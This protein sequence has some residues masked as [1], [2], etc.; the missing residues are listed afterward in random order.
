MGRIL[1]CRDA[2]RLI[3]RELDA[4]LPFWR[5]LLLRVHLFLCGP[6]RGFLRQALLLR[7]AM[8]RYRS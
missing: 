8:R 3:S 4:P 5:W 1:N 7:E 2:S 6:C